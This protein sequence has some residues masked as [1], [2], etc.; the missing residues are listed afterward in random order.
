MTFSLEKISDT[1]RA[2][3]E[4]IMEQT[5]K[6]KKKKAP[7]SNVI[8]GVYRGTT[9]LVGSVFN[10]VAG[11]VV[12]PVRGAKKQGVKGATLGVGK[13]ILGLICKPIAGSIDMITHTVRGI[14]N[15]PGTI[16]GGAKKIF[17]KKI[18]GFKINYEYPPIRPY[19]PGESQSSK[20]KIYIGEDEEGEIYVDRDEL[21]KV[22]IQH[23]ISNDQEANNEESKHPTDNAA[24][25]EDE[26]DSDRI[27]MITNLIRKKHLRKVRNSINSDD[28]YLSCNS[29]FSESFEVV[30]ADDIEVFMVKPI[31]IREHDDSSSVYDS[32]E[33]EDDE[34]YSNSVSASDMNKSS[35]Y[36]SEAIVPDSSAIH[37]K[38]LGSI[39]NKFTQNKPKKSKKS[40]RGAKTENTLVINSEQQQLKERILKM[41][42]N[43][44][45]VKRSDE[46]R[47]SD[48]HNNGGFALTDKVIINKYRSVAKEVI[49]RVGSQILRGKINLT[50]VS[51][52]IKCMG[53]MSHLEALGS[54]MSV[55]PSYLTASAYQTDPIERMKW[56]LTAMISSLTATHHFEKPLNP[57]LGETYISSCDDG[58]IA[59]CEQTSHKP[60]ITHAQFYGPDECYTF[61]MYTG[62]A[63]KAG[64]N[65]VTLNCTGKKSI[66][67][68]NG[69]EIYCKEAPNDIIGNTFFGTLYHQFIDT[70]EYFDDQ[71][72]IYA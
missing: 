25:N 27:A 68:Q 53:K 9:V 56:F 39:N 45:P 31:E 46:Y 32:D 52:P 43:I 10:G 38:T 42:K 40:N 33:E 41:A 5:V 64:F 28:E 30:S 51:F 48:A 8:S 20:N 23:G 15:T 54:I 14:G 12:Q 61:S 17:R 58:T 62:F 50:S 71:N 72:N 67:Y 34:Y 47:I 65:S 22:L 24:S 2:A 29:S 21:K 59:Y 70:M 4:F 60:P 11:L 3:P 37:I 36:E 18:T 6:K 13:G 66:K 1:T 69:G 44:Q 26:F 35:E 19:I 63:A 7:P 16:Y 57:I 49:K 55:F